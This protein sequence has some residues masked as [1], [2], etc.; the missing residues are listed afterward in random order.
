MRSIDPLYAELA[1]VVLACAALLGAGILSG[2]GIIPLTA[3]IAAYAAWN[4][5]QLDR[6][7]K[8]LEHPKRER[9]PIA[10]GIWKPVTDVAL[11]MRNRGKNRKKRLRDILGG[12][13]AH[14]AVYDLELS[15]A[16]AA[17]NVA[18]AAEVSTT[19]TPGAIR[20][21]APSASRTG[22]TAVSETETGDSSRTPSSASCS[23]TVN[24][25]D[26]TAASTLAT[27]VAID[28]GLP[29]RK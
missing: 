2:T 27:S 15:R 4:L 6:F 26:E 28:S 14:R 20:S 8:W 10:I 12:F 21:T 22:P 9:A 16:D 7:R 18:A 29:D 11:D 3:G 13:Q 1:A 24:A 25:P 19:E 23:V 17:S 5:Y